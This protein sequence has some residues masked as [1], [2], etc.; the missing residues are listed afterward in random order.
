M[1]YYHMTKLCLFTAKHNNFGKK[2]RVFYRFRITIA[3]NTNF[4]KGIKY[5][6][7]ATHV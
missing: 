7:T 3:H 5:K 1:Y 6:G 2:K 4:F